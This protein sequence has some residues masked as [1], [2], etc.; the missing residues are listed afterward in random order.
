MQSSPPLRIAFVTP[1]FVTEPK[2]DGGLA[3]YLART[4]T[5]LVAAGHSV[6]LFVLSDRVE[7]LEYNGVRVHRVAQY[8]GGLRTSLLRKI[9]RRVRPLLGVGRFAT[10]RENARRLG[11]AVA[12]FN[13]RFDVVQASD[14]GGTGRD[15]PHSAGCLVTRLSWNRIGTREAERTPTTFHARLGDGL[16]AAAVRRSVRCYAPSHRIAEQMSQRFGRTVDVVRPPAAAS[17]AV[18]EDDRILRE[19]IRREIGEQ[20]Y[21]VFFGRVCRVKGADLLGRILRPLMETDPSLHLVVVGR[22]DL[23]DVV[24]E[25]RAELPEPTRL[26]LTGRLPHE[27]LFPIVRAARA[28]VLPSRIDNFPNVAIEATQAGQIVV[29]TVEGSLTELLVDGESGYIGSVDDV[30][31]LSRRVAAACELDG[32]KREAMVQAA[33]Q[34]L[35]QLDPAETIP[36]LVAYYRDAIAE[37]ATRR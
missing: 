36:Q 3:N 8:A 33:R 17:S 10:D 29:G 15:V 16:E 4:A 26:L 2:F 32:S 7:S 12:R 22:A 30:A 24:D 13:G 37:R 6:D 1:E 31:G 25:I 5:H 27:Q 19:Q 18:I 20:P 23:P 11:E 14:Y 21:V 28:A 34:R 9:E 35:R